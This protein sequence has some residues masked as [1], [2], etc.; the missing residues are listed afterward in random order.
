MGHHRGV[1]D[2]KLTVRRGYDAVSHRYRAD[3]AAPPGYSGWVR[4]AEPP[5]PGD[6]LDLGCGC[7]VPVARDLAARGHR[8]V[9]VDLSDVQIE[10]ARRLVP[11]ARFVREDAAEVAF[12]PA[13]FD[14]VVCLYMLIHLPVG[15]Q[16][17]L[18]HRMRR[19]LRADGMLL[20]TVGSAAWTGTDDD[21]LG[22]SMWWSHPD[23]GTYR[24]WLAA[25]GFA[26]ER[27]E[28]VPEGDGG[29]QLLQARAA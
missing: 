17:A 21:W 14:L 24:R 28:F 18:V 16:E 26:V 12:A 22:A 11:G 3:D 13:S 29:H 5:D 25:A 7:G 23:A 8:V 6:V 2:P 27:D 4:G 15:E 19:W 20:A 1:R 10:R 9:G